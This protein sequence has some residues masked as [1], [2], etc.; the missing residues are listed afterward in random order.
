MVAL[1]TARANATVP[2]QITATQPEHAG[3][4]R[5]AMQKAAHANAQIVAQMVAIP[6]VHASKQKTA[7]MV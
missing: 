4:A 5:M 6:T 3:T 7:K 1:R 2:A